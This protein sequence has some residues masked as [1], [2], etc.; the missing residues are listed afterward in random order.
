MNGKMIKKFINE[1]SNPNASIRRIAAEKLSNGDERAVYPLIKALR[2]EN[3]GVQDA[4]MRSLIAIGGEMVSYMVIPLLRE[5]NAYLRNIA[6]L[7]LKSIGKPVLPLLPPLFRDYD[8]DIRKFAVDLVCEIGECEYPELIASLLE[9]DINPNVRASAAKAIGTL[10]YRDGI[11]SL[12]VG[13]QDEEWVCFSALESIGMLKDESLIDDIIPLLSNGSEA[14][15]FAAIEALGMIGSKGSLEVL[16]RHLYKATEIEKIEILK[17]LIKNDIMPLGIDMFDDLMNMLKEG[18]WEE[19]LIAIKGLILLRREDA[20]K[21]ILHIA[22]MIDP[23]NP[24]EENILFNIKE[25]LR[26]INCS[27][28][29]IE[30]IKDS[31]VR[32]RAKTI[33]IE[34]TGEMECVEAIPYLIGLIEDDIRDVKRASITAIGKMETEESV[35]FLI[36]AIDDPDGHVRKA[37]ISA[38]GKIGR[39]SAF[40]P[41]LNILNKEKY[42]DVIEEAINALL[43]IDRERFIS[44]IHTL[45]EP[46]KELA[47]QI[48][49]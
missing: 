27:N 34:L 25:N 14:L 33:A 5:E 20:I 47:E 3:T 24:E 37:A 41:I 30:A 38:L 46:I 31:K 21:D 43:L 32:F 35:K 11:K 2:D 8:E 26:K 13:L 1:L 44:N 42:R 48:G 36:D 16:E 9:N 12:R 22:G 29:L 19:R 18:Q 15:R 39:E 17:W 4:A 10:N 6:I 49:F 28:E 45:S 23:S 40:I 7:I